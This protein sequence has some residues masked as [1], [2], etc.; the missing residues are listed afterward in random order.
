MKAR[1]WLI[2]KLGGYTRNEYALANVFKPVVVKVPTVKIDKIEVREAI[3]SEYIR[4]DFRF[5]EFVKHDMA[6][7]IADKLIEDGYL[8][9]LVNDQCCPVRYA[10]IIC[11]LNVVKPEQH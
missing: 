4:D 10:E 1:N 7:K 2:K 5:E 3:D 11:R 6:I 8:K 9:F